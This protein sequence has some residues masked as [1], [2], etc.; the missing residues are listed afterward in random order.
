MTS[1]LLA[2]F[3]RSLRE[4]ARSRATY[5]TRGG[6]GFFLL[7]V[8]LLFALPSVWGNAPGRTLFSMVITIQA[9]VI[10]FV[11]LSYFASAVAEEKEEQTLG[12]LRMTGLNPL[13]ILLGKSTSRLCGAL[14]L[15]VAQ[16]PFTVFSITLGG[17]SLWQITAA[18]C[19]LAAFVFLLCNLALLGSVLARTTGG[20]VFFCLVVFGLW[21]GIL[22]LLKFT[23]FV[24]THLGTPL[25]FDAATSA[26]WTATPMARLTEVLGTGF[27]GF[28]IGWQ[29]LSNLAFGVCCFLLAWAAF[30]RFCDRLSEGA[31]AIAI[32][33]PP[34]PSPAPVQGAVA[35]ITPPPARKLFRGIFASRPPRVW[36]DAL[37]WKD[38]YFLC[39]G[40]RGFAWRVLGYGAGIVYDVWQQLV[41]GASTMNINGTAQSIIPFIFSID[42]GVMASRIFRTELRDQTLAAL[43][44]L[45]CDMRSIV[46]HKVFACLLAAAP[47]ALCAASI[48]IFLLVS[49]MGNSVAPDRK[50]MILEL[51]GGWLQTLLMLNVV[52][53]LS[54]SLKR[55]ALA[56]G[57]VLTFLVST[58]LSLLVMVAATAGLFVTLAAL[59]GS[60]SANIRAVVPYLQPALSILV[61][62]V[63]IGIFYHRGLRDL[64]ILAAES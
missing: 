17:I 50:L 60:A 64:E 5:W 38:F 32:R 36:K 61:A 1:P 49:S 28:P 30:E 59:T 15:L 29:F 51:F 26:M 62:I 44:T 6:L 53:W 20:A 31:P 25:S 16:I 57:Y 8:M 27:H 35:V 46:R 9:M 13:S 3:V 19:A 2:L 43:S 63:G 56:L 48:E 18:Y 45:P 33:T 11:G 55:G 34:L 40:S 54:L 47:G 24:S 12:L 23:Q 41:G 10:T 52:A 14:L 37:M 22:S 58:I 21:I 39:G 7:L 42:A 4:D